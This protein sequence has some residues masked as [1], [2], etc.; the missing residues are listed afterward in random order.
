MRLEACDG[1]RIKEKPSTSDGRPSRR[2][3][4]GWLHPFSRL[5][6]ASLRPPP[7]ALVA[8]RALRHHN[9]LL[10][11]LLDSSPNIFHVICLSE[12]FLYENEH[13]CFPLPNY[14]FVGHSRQSR[15]GGV[16]V[17][18]HESYEIATTQKITIYGAEAVS[19]QLAGPI[20]QP[21]NITCI[22][23]MPSADL[24]KFLL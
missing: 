14:S 3:V 7:L 6:L 13:H 21:I 8:A 9:S 17:Y 15:Q 4:P 1:Q 18:V 11:C 2:T 10:Q 24:N 20:K 23:R 22:Y 12:T 16:G 5:G 19:L